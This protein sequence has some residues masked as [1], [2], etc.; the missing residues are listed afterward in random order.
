[1]GDEY[2]P[3]DAQLLQLGLPDDPYSRDQGI[4][5]FNYVANHTSSLWV[6]SVSASWLVVVDIRFLIVSLCIF[7]ATS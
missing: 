5:W 4:Q 3:S 2:Q 7:F 1:M 6:S